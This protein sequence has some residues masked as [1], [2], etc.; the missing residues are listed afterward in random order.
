MF[1]PYKELNQK[2]G[3]GKAKRL[4]FDQYLRTGSSKYF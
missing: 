3:N 2:F 4:Y 1:C